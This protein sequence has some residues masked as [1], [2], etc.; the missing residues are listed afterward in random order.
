MAKY[1]CL[2][3]NTLIQIKENSFRLYQLG[4]KMF[5]FKRLC[6]YCGANSGISP[7][8]VDAAIKL[9][10]TLAEKNISLIYGGGRKGLMGI[11]ANAVLNH[12]GEVVGVIPEFLLEKELGHTAITKLHVVKNMH[13]RKALMAELA[14]GF[15]IMPG[16]AGSLEEFFEIWTAG[17]LGLH[18]K[19][20]GILNIGDYYNYIL[21]FI[22]HAVESQFIQSV[23]RDMLLIDDSPEGLLEKFSVYKAP[24]DLKWMEINKIEA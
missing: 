20:C 6:I 3:D 13:E 23:Y 7:I 14:E 19:P 10:V 8:Y 15:I 5:A 17:Q 9:G 12:G 21:K 4:F 22:D 16:G 24:K 1:L 18:Q 2:L 11:I